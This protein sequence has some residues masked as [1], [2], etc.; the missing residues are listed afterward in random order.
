MAFAGFSDSTFRFLGELAS[1]DDPAWFEAHRATYESEIVEPAKALVEALG[2]RL[3]AFDPKLQA[4][5]RVRGSVKSVERRRRFPRSSAPRYKDCLDLWFWSGR[6]R[7]WDNSGFFVRLTPARLVLAAGMIEFQKD[8]LARYREHLLDDTRGPELATIVSE[9]RAGGY[10][11]GGE[12]YKRMPV[13]FP[14]EHPR[15]P[16]FKHR[17]L[18]ATLEMQHPPELG[19]P[20]F[21]ELAL[22]HFAR[23][24]PLHAWLVALGH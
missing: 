21:P 6:R 20:S 22:E 13:G 18:F 15:A 11:V 4:I 10:V 23:M 5:P 3:K 14:P 2:P 9:L 8:T 19:T 16:L 1:H 7:S 24:A 17:G 12:G